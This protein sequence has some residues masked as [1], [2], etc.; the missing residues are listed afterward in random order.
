M[1]LRRRDDPTP[2]TRAATTPSARSAIARKRFAR[3]QW[4]RRWLAWR[5]SWSSLVLRRAWWPAAL[6]LVFF[7]SVLAVDG[8]PRS[9]GARRA[10]APRDVRRAAAVRTAS[11][12]PASTSTRSARRVE[13]LA[14]VAS[15]RRD[16]VLAR[17]VLIDVTERAPVAVVDVGGRLRGMDADGVMFRDYR[18]AAARPAA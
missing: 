5:S 1:S 15:R 11:R 16:P 7:S 18:Q 13:A 9:S 3:R 4:A 17:P 14:A 8:R 10:R 6:W 2:A 12:W